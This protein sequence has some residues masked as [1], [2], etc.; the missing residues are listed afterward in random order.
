MLLKGTVEWPKVKI[1]EGIV[2]CIDDDI[3]IEESKK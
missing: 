1:E 3:V 2:D